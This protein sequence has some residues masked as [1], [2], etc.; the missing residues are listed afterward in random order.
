MDERRPGPQWPSMCYRGLEVKGPWH[1]IH[2]LPEPHFVTIGA[3]VGPKAVTVR[4]KCFIFLKELVKI[5]FVS[6]W[7]SMKILCGLIYISGE[8]SFKFSDS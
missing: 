4:R 3:K 2:P 1:N 6:V 7:S 5:A 8:P